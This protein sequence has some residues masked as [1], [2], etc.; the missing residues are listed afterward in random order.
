MNQAEDHA[1]M[2]VRPPVLILGTLLVASLLELIWR[3][4]PGLANGTPRPILIGLVIALLGATLVGRAHAHFLAM[5]NAISPRRP[6][7]VLV[8]RRL[9]AWSRNPVYIGLLIVYFGLVV[10]LSIVWGL[11]LLPFVLSVF[12]RAVIPAEEEYLKRHFGQAYE[13][14]AAKVPRWV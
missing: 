7:A 9:F 4:G 1:N 8:T 14:Y 11:I 10:A 6:I 3:L 12:Q 5:G 2:P 13:A